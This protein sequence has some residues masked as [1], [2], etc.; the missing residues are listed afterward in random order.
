MYESQTLG[1]VP[2]VIV[3]Q[4]N[5]EQLSRTLAERAAAPQPSTVGTAR[6]DVLRALGPPVQT[7]NL[8]VELDAADQLAEPDQN[9][10]VVEHGLHPALASLERL[11]HPSL[12]QALLSRVSAQI[13]RVQIC[14]ADVPLILFIWGRSR[15]LPVRLT[16]LSVTEEAFDQQLNPIRARVELGMRVLT[17]ME[18]KDTSLG[19]AAYLAYEQLKETLARQSLRAAR[20]ISGLPS[21]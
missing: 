3:F 10:A 4:Y 9:R 5:P 13:G 19:Y 16:N 18:L 20:F 6:E 1:L 21:F 14:V 11:L 7:M 2:N 12:E 8:T 17:Y 15:V